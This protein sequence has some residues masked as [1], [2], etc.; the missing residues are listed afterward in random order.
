MLCNTTHGTKY[1]EIKVR[2]YVS[3]T[4][5]VLLI[6]AGHIKR[7]EHHICPRSLT[8]LSRSNLMRGGGSY[9]T[10]CTLVNKRQNVAVATNNGR[11][12]DM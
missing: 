5:T 4:A 12:F 10:H 9:G 7:Q 1:I 2:E 8:T 3:V 6:G 11:I